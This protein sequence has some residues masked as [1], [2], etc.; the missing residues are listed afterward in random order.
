M[1]QD[2]FSCVW[3]VGR[4]VLEFDWPLL[5]LCCSERDG[6]PLEGSVQENDISS[7]CRKHILAS[8]CLVMGG[9]WVTFT[10][11]QVG[12]KEEVGRLEV[13]KVKLKK[14]VRS[15]LHIF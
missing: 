3:G 8:L 14:M 7:H 1:K 4:R 5:E 12:R 15:D 10:A 13:T 11:I 9:I 6:K 2:D